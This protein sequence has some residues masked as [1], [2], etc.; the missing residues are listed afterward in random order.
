M[1]RTHKYFSILVILA[2]VGILVLPVGVV[3]AQGADDGGAP[4][5]LALAPVVS[6][7]LYGLLGIILYGVGYAVFDRLMRLDLRRELVEDQNDALGI[8]MAGVFIG[9]GIII[10]ATMLS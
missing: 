7:L 6:T 3:M 5:D 8:M 9:I 2:L 4:Y 10:A 1:K